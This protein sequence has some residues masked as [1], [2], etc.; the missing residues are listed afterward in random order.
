MK[1]FSKSVSRIGIDMGSSQTRIFSEGQ[2]LLEE[3]TVVAVDNTNDD[4]LG[5]G[6][7][8]IIH[9]HTE[10]QRVRLEWPVKN[11]AMIDY[12][13]TRGI[14]SYFLKKGLKHSLSRPEIVIS[15]PSGLSSVARHALIDAT[16]HAGA[17]KVYLVSSSAAAIFGQG[18]SL[19][20][21]DVILSVVMG[22]DITDCG[23]FSC[24]GIV[25]QEQIAFGGNSINEEIQAYVRDSLKIVIGEE[26][27][28]VIKQS[29]VS[30]ADPNAV[31]VF[32]IHGRRLVDG[33]AVAVE[34]NTT[35]LYQVIQTALMPVLESIE[36]IIRRATPDMA[37]DL[38]RNGLLLSGGAAQL[39]GLNHWLSA[40]LGIPVVITKHSDLAVVIGCYRSFDKYR[41]FPDLIESGDKYYGGK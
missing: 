27:A 22:R 19:G 18:I 35:A 37:E 40:Q 23:L 39:S 5:F 1:S 26:E 4:I 33:G 13:Y 14:L 2:L 41:Q 28:E 30:I 8:A 20:G 36:R 3:K 31:K 6:T 10:P 32:T 15:I 25:A 11:G 34:I 21:S 16:M 38:L 12:Y 17:A 24:G 9:Y 7:D 29:M